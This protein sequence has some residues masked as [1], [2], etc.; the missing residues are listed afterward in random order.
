[1]RSRAATTLFLLAALGLPPAAHA[2]P[3]ALAAAPA[4][5]APDSALPVPPVPP[6]IAQG[7]DYDSCLAM[8]YND[9]QGA[10]T[11]ASTW[12][13]GGAND[14][15]THCQ[16]LAQIELGNA[17]IGAQML[18]DLARHS[19]APDL[20]RA[21]VFGQA[22]QAWMMANKPSRA[23]DAATLALALSPNDVG[24]LVD[25][26]V[27]AGSMEQYQD[28]VTDLNHALTIDPRRVEA[29][30]LRSSAWRHLD[31]IDKAR[32]DI[33]AALAFD[34]D[35]ADALLERGILRQR[36]GD[37][38]GARDDWQRAMTLDPNSTTADLAQQDLALLDVGPKQ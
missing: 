25:R 15:A 14:G 33:D 11:F 12:A 24:L 31:H 1:M 6:R 20:A 28:A 29:L 27:A 18:E 36:A 3:A 13:A 38:V 16:G 22:V 26:A 5:P 10:S 4:S 9:P 17:E 30:V 23:F 32:D 21:A 34:P 2:Q 19:T 8:L 37:P 7:A 35:N